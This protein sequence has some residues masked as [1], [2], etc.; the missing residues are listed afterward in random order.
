M[1]DKITKKEATQA[2]KRRNKIKVQLKV[3]EKN[4]FKN[5]GESFQVRQKKLIDLQK[6]LSD[7]Y[8]EFIKAFQ[9]FMVAGN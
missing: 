1:T 6:E 5:S 9:F 8:P 2:I 3:A 7:Q 4:I